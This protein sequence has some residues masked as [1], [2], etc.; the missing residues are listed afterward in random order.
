MLIHEWILLMTGSQG[1]QA[2]AVRNNV[3][4]RSCQ[5]V[6]LTLI[7]S[8]GVQRWRLVGR[9]F[10]EV[11]GDLSLMSL[12]VLPGWSGA[13]ADMFCFVPLVLCKLVGGK[14][15]K[16]GPCQG[17][18]CMSQWVATKKW[19][20]IMNWLRWLEVK[21]LA[22][23]F[24]QEHQ[25][26]GVRWGVESEKRWW[27]ESLRKELERHGVLSVLVLEFDSNRRRGRES[28]K[29]RQQQDLSSLLWSG[30]RIILVMMLQCFNLRIKKVNQAKA[31]GK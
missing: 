30:N 16:T 24:F 26:W 8:S 17:Y 15:K 9:P 1:Q 12:T 18:I 11:L 20:L 6:V 14:K 31:L 2:A 25:L 4:L 23:C 21:E 27:V 22:Q 19:L 13:A 10:N 29:S 3:N 7:S 5:R 28:W